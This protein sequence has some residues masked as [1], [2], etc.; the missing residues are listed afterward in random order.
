MYLEMRHR[1]GKLSGW[2]LSPVERCRHFLFKS[3]GHEAITRHYSPDGRGI[4]RR[5]QDGTRREHDFYRDQT[6]IV[7]GDF[8]RDQR[9]KDVDDCAVQ[10]GSW[11][12]QVAIANS[13]RTA[14]SPTH[15]CAVVPVKSKTALP[16]SGSMVIA[17]LMVDPSSIESSARSVCPSNAL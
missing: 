3:A 14:T 13:Q 16:S 7:E 4:F 9:P 5:G 12:V 6:T 15:I 10:D 2:Y 11:G 8:N 17:N 1:P